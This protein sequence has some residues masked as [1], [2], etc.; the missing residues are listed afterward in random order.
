ME[1][2]HCERSRSVH[3]VRAR[4]GGL[5]HRAG[6]TISAAVVPRTGADAGSTTYLKWMEENWRSA[7]DYRA[8]ADTLDF[9][10]NMT[11]AQHTGEST[12][13]PVAGFPWMEASIRYVLSLGVPARKISLGIP[14]YWTTGSP[15]TIPAS[16]RACVAT[17]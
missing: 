13:G 16:V 2:V 14:A 5:V 8:L 9:I 1:N 11:Y 6:C 4:I 15:R 7:Y 10:S 17:M 3:V 12:P